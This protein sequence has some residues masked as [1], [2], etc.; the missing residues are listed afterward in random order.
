MTKEK[1]RV[2]ICGKITGD[3]NFGEK[4]QAARELLEASGYEVTSPVS[5]TNPVW[6]RE[7]CMR[8]VIREL[9]LCDAIYLLPDWKNSKGARLEAIIA[10]ELKMEFVKLKI[11]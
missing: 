4:F 6:S 1:T 7:T 11:E 10:K 2:Y 9:C 3:P 8:V 5:Y